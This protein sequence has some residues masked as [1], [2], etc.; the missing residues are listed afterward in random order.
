MFNRERVRPF[1]LQS[2]YLRS[3]SS[4]SPYSIEAYS[5]ESYFVVGLPQLSLP[6][7]H[8]RISQNHGFFTYIPLTST[9]GMCC[10]G[11]SAR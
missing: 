1:V 2:F 3:I 9:K 6:G 11:L 8:P 7:H 5:V 4:I 10:K